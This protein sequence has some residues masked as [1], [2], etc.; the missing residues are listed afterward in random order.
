MRIDGMGWDGMGWD[1]MGWD[2]VKRKKRR[3]TKVTP[4]N[5]SKGSLNL[6]HFDAAL[7]KAI[8]SFAAQHTLGQK[9]QVC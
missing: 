2:V 4:F 5:S 9:R 1:G 6:N 7:D 8:Q 3:N